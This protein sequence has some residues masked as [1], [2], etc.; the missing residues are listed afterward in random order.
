MDWRLRQDGLGLCYVRSTYKSMFFEMARGHFSARVSFPSISTRPLQLDP[1]MPSIV[2]KTCP[3]TC[4][5]HTVE[6]HARRKI[7][8]MPFP[9]MHL[10]LSVHPPHDDATVRIGVRASHPV[11]LY[12]SGSSSSGNGLVAASSI[13]SLYCCS[14]ASSTCTVGGAKARPATNS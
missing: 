2:S 3:K 6:N 10:F 11:L 1:S 5:D 9:S 8:S 14:R 13:S 4:N 12:I 7:S